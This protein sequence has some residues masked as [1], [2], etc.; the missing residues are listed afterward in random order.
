MNQCP[1][2]NN[3]YI[4]SVL[5]SDA[6]KNIPVYHLSA[7][8][9]FIGELISRMTCCAAG[10]GRVLSQK[11]SFLQPG[12]TCCVTHTLC[13]CVSSAR[14]SEYRVAIRDKDEVV[15]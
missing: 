11:S 5:T 13:L 12:N 14:G 9:I 7:S 6:T 4:L 10:G 3:R 8:N 1:L 2:T 15:T